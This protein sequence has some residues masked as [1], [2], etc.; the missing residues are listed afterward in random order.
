MKMELIVLE[1]AEMVWS[2]RWRNLFRLEM[3]CGLI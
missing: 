1:T 2:R 3:L